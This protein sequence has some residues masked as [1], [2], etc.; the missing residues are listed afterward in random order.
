MRSECVS[1]GKFLA[2][3]AFDREP[4]PAP[5]VVLEPGSMPKR[6]LVGDRKA[7][8]MAS[9]ERASLTPRCC[10]QMTETGKG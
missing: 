8:H 1:G 10:G 3:F 9:W 7:A 2:S 5:L 4:W 6:S